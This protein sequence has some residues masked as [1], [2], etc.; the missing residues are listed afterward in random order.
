MPTLRKLILATCVLGTVTLGAACSKGKE[1]AK[2]DGSVVARVDGKAITTAELQEELDKLPPYLK[3]RVGTPEGRREFLDNLLTRKAL[4]AEADHL[5]LE[6][7]PAI[8]KQITEYRERLILQK[9]MQ[10]RIPKEP[11]LGEDE[12]RKYYDDNADEFKES[13]QVRVR[14]VLIKSEASEDAAKRQIARKKAEQVLARA[15]GGADF[16]KLAAETSEDVGSKSKGGDLGFFP[17]G[18]M[19]KAFEDAAF[20]LAKPKELSGVI[21]TQ[22]GYHV[23]QFLEIQ[24]SKEKSFEEAKEQIRRR[25]APQKQRESYQ[26][27]ITSIKAK[28]KIEVNDEVLSAMVV[29]GKE[30]PK[31]AKMEAAAEAE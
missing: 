15:K 27:F 19:A 14:H 22:F 16:E 6:R 26:D 30:T 7:D 18:R 1:G 17:R 13:A 10:D 20:S 5:G 12:I 9:L 25:L 8:A 4:M 11:S 2:N 28:H 23:I 29:G 21:E 31:P 24:E 3:G